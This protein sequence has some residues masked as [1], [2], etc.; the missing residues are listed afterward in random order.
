MKVHLIFHMTERYGGADVF[1]GLTP[2][3]TD[4]LTRTN[5]H[6]K[7]IG[8]IPFRED[9]FRVEEVELYE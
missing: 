8:E 7:E 4:W 3:F 5:L 1:R 6:R 9:E 2:N